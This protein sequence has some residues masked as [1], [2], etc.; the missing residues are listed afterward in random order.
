ML[1][2][3]LDLALVSASEVLHLAHQSIRVDFEGDPVAFLDVLE[4]RVA[5]LLFLQFR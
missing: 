1:L 2:K 5:G 4:P 3:R